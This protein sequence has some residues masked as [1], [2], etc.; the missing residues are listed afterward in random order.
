MKLV[1]RGGVPVF[2]GR[3]EMRSA[4]RVRVPSTIQGK[5]IVKL[6]SRTLFPAMLA[7]M[8]LEPVP[9]VADEVAR[10]TCTDFADRAWPRVLVGY[11]VSFP[12]GKV[13]QGKTRLVDADGSEHAHQLV[14][15]RTH[16]DGSVQAGRVHFYASLDAGGQYDFRLESGTDAKVASR[17]TATQRGDRLHVAS[18]LLAIEVPAPT[19]KA[20]DPPVGSEKVLA[21]ILKFRLSSNKWAGQGLLRTELKVSAMSQT[22]VCAGPLLHETAYRLEFA[23][24]G[25]YTMR[26]RV[27]KELPLVHIAEEFDLGKA[28]PNVN[29]FVLNMSKGWSPSTAIW[30]SYAKPSPATQIRRKHTLHGVGTWKQ[31]LD[32]NSDG[33]HVRINAFQDFG[34]RAVWYG[35]TGDTG[36][37]PYVGF[38]S[39]HS[40]AWRLVTPAQGEIH[41]G[42]DR[43][44]ELRLP[45]N[46]YM[47]GEPMNPFSTAEIDP[48]VPRTLGRRH[49]ALVLEP[50]STLEDGNFDPSPH[51]IYRRYYGSISLNDYKDW[52]VEWPDRKLSYPRVLGDRKSIARLKANV[53]RCPDPDALRSQYLISGDDK[54][55]ENLLNRVRVVSKNRLSGFDCY[56]PHFR[57]FQNDFEVVAAID[58]VL[59]WPKLPP[60]DRRVLRARMAIMAYM[61]TNANYLPRGAGVHLGN[62][63]MAINRT[64]GI[65]LYGRMLSDHPMARQWLDD[66]YEYLKWSISHD[67]TAAGGQFRECPG[68][69]TYGPMV[70]IAIAAKAMRDAGYDIDRFAPLKEMGKW[71]IDV[72]TAPTTPRGWQVQHVHKT[73]FDRYV[74]DKLVRVLPG[75][76]NGRDIPGGQVAMLLAN[77]F[78][79]SDPKFA[80]ELMGVFDDM[81]KFL[82]TESTRSSM[83]FY[84]N[85]DIRPARP[86][87]TDRV[88]TGF[89][90][91]LRAHPG[92]EEINVQLRQGYVQSHWNPDQ[93]TFMLYARGRC[94]APPT[95]WVYDSA[96]EGM[97]RDSLIAF[98]SEFAGHEH[99]RADTLIRD[100]GFLPSLAY[101]DGVQTYVRNEGVLLPS[102]F[103]WH[104]Q[105]LLVRSPK[106]TSPNY[107]LLRD[108]MHGEKLLPSWWYQWLHTKAESVKPI[109]N[110]LRAT[111]PNNVMMD[112]IFLH[113]NNV[114]ASVKNG[115]FRSFA[116]EDYCQI[117]LNRSAGKEYCVLFYP[118][119]SGEP[120]PRSA[121]QLA[122][123]VI[124]VK[125]SESE[126][127]LFASAVDPIQWQ[128]DSISFT[129]HAGMVR[130]K[131]G[132]AELVNATS[133]SATISYNGKEHSGTGPWEV[134]VRGNSVATIVKAPARQSPPKPKGQN[135]ITVGADESI[136]DGKVLSDGIQGWVAINDDTI[137]LTATEG[138]GRIGY[139]D[140]YVKGEAPFTATWKPGEI[141]LAAKGRRRVFVMPIPRN[142]LPIEDLPPKDDLPDFIYKN[143]TT[144]GW[145]NWPVA[146][147]IE[148]D[149]YITQA[150]WFNG[151]MAVGLDENASKATIRPYTNP[152]VW[153]ENATTRLLPVPR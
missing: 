82:G 152:S 138:L 34:Q 99:G 151:L 58:T 142:L 98:G 5:H 33:L 81:G 69:A 83:W 102:P 112:T 126:D 24:T 51:Y 40:G 13:F 111:F 45:L 20:F 84:W 103:D 145:I 153:R 75:L 64:L 18:P 48:D 7:I 107:V 43:S 46:P 125:T 10:F 129:G 31:P 140:F 62:P 67:V 89:G 74:K 128:G 22:V 110:G 36:A 136:D 77:V 113:D 1:I 105:T 119:K 96:P 23:P 95:G 68:Y 49:W 80:S 60:E 86:S 141:T 131:N 91:V 9:G 150:G 25:Y 3:H 37:S 41:W 8:L 76:G 135:V 70:F 90:G 12:R 106:V 14:V 15:T 108:T 28:G 63:N 97:F 146:P 100:Y 26:V 61:L 117:R 53:E 57:Q 39:Q 115:E 59:A 132:R 66:A 123:G 17:V 32:F 79:K 149:G 85:P 44:V 104:R 122:P 42:K 92:Q 6:T 4:D 147:A 29:Q 143:M 30:T 130:V 94:L 109:K 127:Y 71:Y 101:L 54:A 148:I 35:L 19:K 38:M 133:R 116:G 47:Q 2:S 124:R 56:V 78:A 27:E 72:A 93:G 114:K 137:T 21:P 50:R 139:G 55:A 120:A 88:I 134:L 73:R 16:S 65:T 118:Y 52:V 87:Y 11:D 144:Y 121:E